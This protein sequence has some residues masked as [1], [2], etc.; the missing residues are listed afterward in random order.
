MAARIAL[1]A[2]FVEPGVVGGTETYTRSLVRA[3][4]D[5][6][7]E[8]RYTLY[9]AREAAATPW[10]VAA[11]VEIRATPAT[12]RSRVRR[13]G[14]ELAWL[15]RRA[16]RDGAG[17]LHSMGTTS[18]LWGRLP[19]VVTV[20]DLIY[21]A[22]PDVF[23]KARLM[24]LRALVPRMLRRADRVIT[25]SEASARDIAERYDVPRPKIVVIHLGPGRAPLAL[26]DDE[27]DRHVRD[28]G[29]REP[30][31]LSV[32]T[33]QRHKNLAALIE[34]FAQARR[35]EPDLTLALV[36]AAGRADATLRAAIVRAGLADA[37]ALCGRVDD[38]TLD[39]LY[40]RAQLFV[41]PSLYEGFGLPLLEA[42]ERGVPVLSSDATSL[43]EVGGEAC[44]FV[45]ARRPEAIAQA[46]VDLAG[47]GERRGRL[48]DAGRMRAAQFTWRRAAEETIAVYDSVA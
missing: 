13:L 34:A 41:Y 32:A 7:P 24:A 8:R 4:G 16:R 29:V 10:D 17:V 1:N 25:I 27:I 33:T 46:I 35:A 14:T 20:H 6:A 48:V 21:E 39:A 19:R 11:N 22:Y 43:P 2:L 47:D 23:P 44:E 9:L 3:L 5:A 38:A 30:Y 42:M 45:D 36:G 31:V 26:E 12:A 15:E 37:V 28:A 18:P 40:A